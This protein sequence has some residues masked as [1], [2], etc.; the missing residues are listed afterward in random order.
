MM[1]VEAIKL[2][3]GVGEWLLGRLLMVDAA[4][5]R[6]DEVPVRADPRRSPVTALTRIEPT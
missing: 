1:A 3:T 4:A 2:I 6:W 5:A